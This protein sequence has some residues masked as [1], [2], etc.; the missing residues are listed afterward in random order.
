MAA[1][2]QLGNTDRLSQGDQR[3][4]E[5]DA[6]TE[7]PQAGPFGRVGMLVGEIDEDPFPVMDDASEHRPLRDR[8]RCRLQGALGRMRPE[9]GESAGLRREGVDD[10]VKEA[11]RLRE[12]PGDE[13]TEHRGLGRLGEVG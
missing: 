4:Q 2:S 7:C 5:H 13:P 3:Q 10:A 9:R 6:A 12:V 8:L 1:G 11:G